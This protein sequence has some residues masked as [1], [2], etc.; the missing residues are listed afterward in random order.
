MAIVIVQTLSDPQQ[1]SAVDTQALTLTNPIAASNALIA[2]VAHIQGSFAFPAT[3]TDPSATF[4]MDEQDGNAGQGSSNIFSSWGNVGGAQTVTNN[5]NSSSS[6]GN[7]YFDSQL[8][9]VSGVVLTNQAYA[10]NT[11]HDLSGGGTGPLTVSTSASVNSGDLVVAMCAANAIG[12]TG[13]SIPAGWNPIGSTGLAISGSN[14]PV[15]AFAY[16]IPGSSGSQTANF[17]SLGSATGWSAIIVAYPAGIVI[18][19]ASI[20]WIT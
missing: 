1:N 12:A 9:E 18:P 14:Y 10:G 17:G 20:A 7:T 8:M 3:P 16:K 11:N 19:S 13:L 5:K 4:L 6:T 2:L 15:A